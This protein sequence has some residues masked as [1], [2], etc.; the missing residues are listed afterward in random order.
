MVFF[1]QAYGLNWAPK[2]EGCEMINSENLGLSLF[3]GLWGL[4]F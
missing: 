1:Q 4:F 3:E 2:I